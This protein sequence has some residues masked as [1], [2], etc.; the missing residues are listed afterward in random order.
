[1]TKYETEF[2]IPMGMSPRELDDFIDRL[3]EFGYPKII[4][5]A[6]TSGDIKTKRALANEI[7]NSVGSFW[8]YFFDKF[9]PEWWYEN[10]RA[11]RKRSN[12]GHDE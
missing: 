11:N 9:G 8:Y 6:E 4:F 5:R 1:M 7:G 10:L 3:R 2:D 12:R